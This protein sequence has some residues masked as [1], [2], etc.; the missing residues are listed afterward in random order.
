MARRPL[1]KRR[2]T[3]LLLCKMMFWTCLISSFFLVAL[4]QP[5]RLPV[6]GLFAAGFGFALFWRAMLYLP[7]KPR[8]FW[9]SFFWFFGVQSIQL[10]WMATTTYM[11]SLILGV[12]ALLNLGLGFQFACLSSLILSKN[13]TFP[14]LP[15]CLALAG[16]WVFFEWSRLFICTGFTWNPLGLFLSNALYSRQMASLFG[17]YGLSF[18]V[19]LTNLLAFRALLQENQK[20]AWLAFGFI[21]LL[22]YCFGILWIWSLETK[23]E[24]SLRALLVQTALLPEQKDFDPSYENSFVPLVQQWKNIL[25]LLQTKLANTPVDLIVFPEG[26][27]PYGAYNYP[28]DLKTMEEVWVKYF[29]EEALLQLPTLQKPLAFLRNH[30]WKVTNAYWAQAIANYYQADVIIGLDDE[31]HN[32]AF[33]FHPDEKPPQRYEKRILVPVAEYIPFSGMSLVSD[34]VASQFG[35]TQ[36]FAAGSEAK[37]FEAKVPLA[38]SICYEETFGELC[39]E[40]RQKGAELFVNVTNDAWFPTSLLAQQHFDHGMIRSVENGV[41]VLRCC[42]TGITG[43]ID[44][45]GRVVDLLEP[46]EEKEGALFLK[47]PLDHHGTYYTF[48]GDSF[49]LWVSSFFTIIGLLHHFKKKPLP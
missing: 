1:P 6:L 9:L 13:S 45:F 49:I 35:I 17:I 34:F 20:R 22:P 4:G 24:K 21:A 29:G 12:Y 36:S 42:N 44:R 30:H 37:V 3:H 25:D 48:W 43:G 28:F 27:L 23:S 7:S 14:R 16:L 19:I 41:S 2:E 46:S 8:Q 18:W 33:L 31:K 38:I 47:I 15:W 5:A 32:A 26:T 39:R 40:G 11:G 10:S